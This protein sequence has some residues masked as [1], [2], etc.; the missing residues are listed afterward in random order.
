MG[1]LRQMLGLPEHLFVSV[2]R[3]SIDSLPVI[4]GTN[5][6][7]ASFETPSGRLLVPSHINPVLDSQLFSVDA[8]I[9]LF[10]WK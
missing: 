3:D 9:T 4:E 1:G 5:K 2:G 10:L 7:G 8:P 6:L